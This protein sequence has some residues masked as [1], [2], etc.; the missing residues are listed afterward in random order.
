VL[1]N[2]TDDKLVCGTLKIY[3]GQ[4]AF[5]FKGSSRE[6]SMLLQSVALAGLTFAPGDEL[7]LSAFAN[8]TGSVDLKLILTV[9]YSGSPSQKMQQHILATSGYTEYIV[10]TLT[11]DSANVTS[12]TVK[13]KH[14][15]TSG[16]T[17]ID[18]VSLK[19]RQGD[20]R[21]GE[22]STLPVPN[23]PSGFRGN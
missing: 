3:S 11:L 10:P 17:F 2:G 5:K 20:A 16:R 12:I 23:I 1:A 15:S 8:S 6:N 4:C 21:R 9:K 18:D 7:I 13:F 19:L 22:G 14:K